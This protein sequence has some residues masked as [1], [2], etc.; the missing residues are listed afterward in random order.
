VER[1]SFGEEAGD[2]GKIRYVQ[3]CMAGRPS[4]LPNGE[5]ARRNFSFASGRER[6][7][8]ARLGECRGKRQADASPGARDQRP[9]AVEP[10]A[11]SDRQSHS[12]TGSGAAAP[13]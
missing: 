9:A 8:R 7:L 1:R 11:G 12:A 5:G 3:Q 6:N 2:R 13:A 4:A 10:E